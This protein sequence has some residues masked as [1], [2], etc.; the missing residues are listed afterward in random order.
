MTRGGKRKGTGPKKGKK[1]ETGTISFRHTKT[2]LDEIRQK[3]KRGELSSL[4]KAWLESL[5]KK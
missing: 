5:V 3:F 4:G 1:P 2:V